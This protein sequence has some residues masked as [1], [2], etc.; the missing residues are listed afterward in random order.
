VIQDLIDDVLWDSGNDGCPGIRGGGMSC[1]RGFQ[2]HRRSP[3]VIGEGKNAGRCCRRQRCQTTGFSTAT[4]PKGNSERNRD[5]VPSQSG[6]IIL[7]DPFSCR[8]DIYVN[9]VIVLV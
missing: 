4:E 9:A 6:D 2:I 7:L 1:C 8:V 3:S 5:K